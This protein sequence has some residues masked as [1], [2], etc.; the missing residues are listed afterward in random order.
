MLYLPKFSRFVVAACVFI[1]ALSACGGGGG[2]GGSSNGG[3]NPPPTVTDT[4]NSY[5]PTGS[6]IRWTYNSNTQLYFSEDTVRDGV[7]VHSLLYPNGSKEYFVTAANQIS[8]KGI[9]IPSISVGNGIVYTGD[10][11][12][13]SPLTIFSSDWRRIDRSRCT[14]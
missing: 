2:G 14:K 10:V 4:P 6:S 1:F 9:Y 12:F 13:S 5:L 3:G 7:H 8:L 11:N